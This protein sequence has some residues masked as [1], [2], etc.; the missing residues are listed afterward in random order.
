MVYLIIYRLSLILA[1]E[2]PSVDQINL[3]MSNYEQFND[4]ILQTV[5]FLERQSDTC[6]TVS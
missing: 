1:Q 3:A 6:P 2:G 4:S 5:V